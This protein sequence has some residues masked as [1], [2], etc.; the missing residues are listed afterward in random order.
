MAAPKDTHKTNRK[1]TQITSPLSSPVANRLLK[2][3]N[4]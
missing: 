1:L 2:S 4:N 3:V